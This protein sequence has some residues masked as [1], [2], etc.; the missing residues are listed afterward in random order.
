M[1]Y[2]RVPREFFALL[3]GDVQGRVSFVKW[4]VYASCGI[5]DTPADRQCIPYS[6]TRRFTV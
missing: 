2:G 6:L 4:H 3:D 1:E 5:T